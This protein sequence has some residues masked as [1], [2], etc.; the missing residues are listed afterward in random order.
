[1]FGT[2][3]M[4]V[5]EF[6]STPIVLALGGLLATTGVVLWVVDDRAVAAR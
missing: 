3:Y 2:G 4:L 5:A 6:P 1:M